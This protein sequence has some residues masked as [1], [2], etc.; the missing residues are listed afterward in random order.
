MAKNPFVNNV[1]NLGSAGPI[2]GGVGIIT[3]GICSA[4]AITN[5]AWNQ[6]PTDFLGNYTQV[7]PL[8]NGNRYVAGIG[9]SYFM[10]ADWGSGTLW[11]FNIPT[12]WTGT[13][14]TGLSS[15]I[16]DT[17]GHYSAYPYQ[18]TLPGAVFSGTSRGTSTPSCLSQ[19][20]L[21]PSPNG[22]LFADLPDVLHLAIGVNVSGGANGFLACGI[23]LTE[24]QQYNR[25]PKLASS[26]AVFPIGRNVGT[27]PNGSYVN[28]APPTM[29]IPVGRAPSPP[30]QTMVNCSTWA[31]QPNIDPFPG[32]ATARSPFVVQLS[33]ANAATQAAIAQLFGSPYFYADY[34]TIAPQPPNYSNWAITAITTPAK[35]SDKNYLVGSQLGPPAYTVYPNPIYGPPSGSPPYYQ[36]IPGLS[37]VVPF[38]NGF[39]TTFTSTAVIN[40]STSPVYGYETLQIK[41]TGYQG[42]SSLSLN[43][44]S[45]WV[46]YFTDTGTW[47]ITGGSTAAAYAQSADFNK[48]PEY[49]GTASFQPGVIGVSVPMLQSAALPTWVDA[50]GLYSSGY[51]PSVPALGGANLYCRIPMRPKG[52]DLYCFALGAKWQT[53]YQNYQG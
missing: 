30:V 35:I 31:T 4:G 39:P 13:C 5:P 21:L 23:S 25:S 41:L 32:L 9:G 2:T 33:S 46:G 50:W 49:S 42:S 11:L 20:T 45:Y 1:P 26:G 3:V 34:E 24:F 22:H 43:F 18:L 10:G 14:W 37:S 44:P 36:P 48:V 27:F 38:P 19:S 29:I 7:W 17:M 16:V 51:G 6:S 53:L 12:H 8:A 47:V 40:S 15:F 28:G 52:Y